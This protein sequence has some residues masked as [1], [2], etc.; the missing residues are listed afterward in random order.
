MTATTS[1]A[2]EHAQ[3]LLLREREAARLL[4]VSP[5]TLWTLAHSGDL[6]CVRFGRSKRYSLAAL[7]R[8]IAERESAAASR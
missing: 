5:R 2:A 8:F 6:P 1:A 3:P 7:Q 4:G